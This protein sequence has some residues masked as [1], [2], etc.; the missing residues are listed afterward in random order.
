MGLSV[1]TVYCMRFRLF[2][3]IPAYAGM[4]ASALPSVFPLS[5]R[6][7]YQRRLVSRQIAGIIRKDSAG[8]NALNLAAEH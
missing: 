3:W 1:F 6:A 4:T 2:K 5:F 7:S 8:L